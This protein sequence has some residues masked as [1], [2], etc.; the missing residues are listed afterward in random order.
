[1]IVF[2]Q[3]KRVVSN[4][5]LMGNLK[6]YP[7]YQ[8]QSVQIQIPTY[9]LK[10]LYAIPITIKDFIHTSHWGPSPSVKLSAM[11]KGF[12]IAVRRQEEKA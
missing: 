11:G 6:T 5:H 4:L 7:Y 10:I 8:L 9:Y 12:S 1:M 3:N 2:V